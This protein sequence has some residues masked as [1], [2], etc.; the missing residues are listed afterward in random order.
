[1]EEIILTLGN[2]DIDFESARAEARRNAEKS[3]PD[4]EII[5]WHNRDANTQSP[6]CLRCE[7]DDGTPAWEMYG[8][9]HGGRL[10]VVVN[11][12]QYVFILS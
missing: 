12:G 6:C 1:M 8:R 2:G 5:S 10:K 11:N 7:Y 4:A 9:N 3:N